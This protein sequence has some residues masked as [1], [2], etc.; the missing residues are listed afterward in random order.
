MGKNSE[1]PFQ[2]TGTV[3]FKSTIYRLEKKYIDKKKKVKDNDWSA[4]GCG[5]FIFERMIECYE[6]GKETKKVK[7]TGKEGTWC[8]VFFRIVRLRKNLILKNVQTFILIYG[9]LFDF[10][11]FIFTWSE[12][13]TFHHFTERFIFLIINK[14]FAIF[15]EHFF[16]LPPPPH[17]NYFRS[18]YYCEVYGFRKR[19][20]KT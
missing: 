16:F 17:K 15:G 20:V 4:V 5:Q 1:R 14:R 10:F 2:T 9:F 8:I 18:W 6:Y 12:S 11:Q 7:S 3:F 19:T 13:R